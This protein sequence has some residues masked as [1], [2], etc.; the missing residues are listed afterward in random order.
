[1]AALTLLQCHTLTL[2]M[3]IGGPAQW[4]TGNTVPLVLM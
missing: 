3:K 1:M 4:L 2:I